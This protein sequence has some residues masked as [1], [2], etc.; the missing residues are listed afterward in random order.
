MKLDGDNPIYPE[1]KVVPAHAGD[2]KFNKKVSSRFLA[3]ECRDERSAAAMRKKLMIAYST[4][5]T[6]VDPI[7]GAF[8]P[9]DAKFTDLE[10]FRRLVH[11]QNQYLAHH[12]NIPLND[13]DETILRHI[14]PNGNDLKKNLRSLLFRMLP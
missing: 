13:L 7:L 6:K 12:R 10:I 1:F 9:F 2:N 5:P 4:L 14:L 8:I 3:I 11:C